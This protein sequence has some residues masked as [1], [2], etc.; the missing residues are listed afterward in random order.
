MQTVKISP[1]DASP[2]V[3]T[4]ISSELVTEENID[5]FT[6][7]KI[8]NDQLDRL[9]RPQALEVPVLT[10][11]DGPI[12]TLDPSFSNNF[13]MQQSSN[14]SETALNTSE[15]NLTEQSP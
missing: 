7:N 5:N 14:F 15:T 2:I 4:E 8:T 6:A 1:S 11:R 10:A 12:S 9:Y 3:L 13:E